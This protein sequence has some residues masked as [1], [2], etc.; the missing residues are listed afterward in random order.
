MSPC[1][2]ASKCFLTV[3]GIERDETAAGQAKL[4]QK[5][6]GSRDFVGLLSDIDMGEH[7]RGVGREGAQ[8]LGRGALAE[9]VEAAAQCLAVERDAALSGRRARRL[10]AGSV[11]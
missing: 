1:L 3:Q 10:K 5:R 9:V 4:G 2:A 11:A 8:H 6:L 7:E